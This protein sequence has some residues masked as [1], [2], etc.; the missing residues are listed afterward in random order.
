MVSNPRDFQVEKGVQAYNHEDGDV[1]E[2]VGGGSPIDAAKGIAI[3]ASNNGSIQD[4]EGCNLVDQPIPFL[5]CAPTTAGT[6]AVVSQL[7]VI[8]DTRK[9]NKM[10]ILSGAIMHD[11]SLIDPRLLQSKPADLMSSTGMDTLTH[12]IEAYVSSLSWPLTDPHAIHAIVFVAR[13]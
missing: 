7:E 4:Y 1:I 11:I 5:I 8:A 3:L 13:L 10:T 9:K 2:A 12:A 6:S